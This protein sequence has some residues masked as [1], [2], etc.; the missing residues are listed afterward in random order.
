MSSWGRSDFSWS[1]Q[2]QWHHDPIELLDKD[3]WTLQN[4]IVYHQFYQTWSFFLPNIHQM[5][6]TL[7]WNEKW[8]FLQKW[9]RFKI[10]SDPRVRSKVDGSKGESGQFRRSERS[11]G[12]GRS[13]QKWTVSSQSER[14]LVKVGGLL[15]IKRWSR[16]FEDWK[17][18]VQKLPSSYVESYTNH[19]VQF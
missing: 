14:S 1:F 7:F 10:W 4:S 3:F 11:R 17:W 5:D 19:T 18:T 8:F 2:R 12:S 15:T 13:F 9:V 6:R 16:N